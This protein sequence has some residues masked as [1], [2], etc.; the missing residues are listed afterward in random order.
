MNGSNE[1]GI[2]LSTRKYL[3]ERLNP[4]PGDPFYLTLSDLSLAL[5]QIIPKIEKTGDRILDF[6]CGGSPYKSLFHRCSEY[7][8]ADLIGTPF[9]D[10]EMSQ[11]DSS[12]QSNEKEFNIIFSS[13]VLEHV[14]SP[15]LYL[16]EALRLL[17]PNGTLILSTHGTYQDHP[18]PNDYWRWTASGLEKKLFEAGFQTK[19]KLFLT[20]GLRAAFCVFEMN[21]QKLGRGAFWTKVVCEAIEKICNILKI[22]KVAHILLDKIGPHYRVKNQFSPFSGIYITILFVAEP[23]LKND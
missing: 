2:S 7:C 18:C 16:K 23:F 12:T 6:G 3:Q 19:E 11:T 14:E 21:L 4:V 8:R 17:K 13:Q 10:F 1:L 9:I 15:E 5:K 20:T 22:R